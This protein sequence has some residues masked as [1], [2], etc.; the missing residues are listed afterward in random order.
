MGRCVDSQAQWK[1]VHFMLHN[2]ATEFQEAN[3]YH[4]N[5]KQLEAGDSKIVVV[6]MPAI[7]DKGLPTPEQRKAILKQKDEHD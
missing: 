4:T 1:P 5:L 3:A 7:P 2:Y 6:Q